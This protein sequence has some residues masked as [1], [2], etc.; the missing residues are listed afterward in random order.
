[1]SYISQSAVRKEEQEIPV[2]GTV[3][4]DVTGLSIVVHVSAHFHNSH[5]LHTPS[6][7]F[8]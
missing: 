8:L 1:M 3:H 2:L 7:Y 5:L 6:L 4:G